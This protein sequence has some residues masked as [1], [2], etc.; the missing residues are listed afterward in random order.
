VQVTFLKKAGGVMPPVV[1]LLAGGTDGWGPWSWHALFVTKISPRVFASLNSLADYTPLTSV[2][3]SILL[4]SPE[5]FGKQC[6]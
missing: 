1:S 3:S 2:L 4:P 6:A 5:S